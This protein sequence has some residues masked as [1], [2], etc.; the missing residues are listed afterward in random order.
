MS[1]VLSILQQNS[2]SLKLLQNSVLSNEQLGFLLREGFKRD[3]YEMR[4]EL[5]LESDLTLSVTVSYVGTIE[6]YLSKGGRSKRV[7]SNKF[8]TDTFGAVYMTCMHA[9][10]FALK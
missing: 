10:T 3:L 8:S 2:P 7:F 9:L 6:C 5:N 1:T 4:L